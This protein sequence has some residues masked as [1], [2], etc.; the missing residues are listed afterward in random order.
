MVLI[1]SRTLSSPSATIFSGVG[2]AAN[3]AG[4]ALLTPASVACAD[5][6]TATRSV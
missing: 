1:S 3:K 4:V 2:A 5:N 6:T